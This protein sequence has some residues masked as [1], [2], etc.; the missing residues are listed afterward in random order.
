MEN[1][2]V[3]SVSIFDH[4]LTEKEASDCE[5]MNYSTAVENHVLD[6][7][8]I[9]ENKFI[10]LYASLGDKAICYL[11][12]ERKN[13]LLTNSVEFK[14]YLIKGLREKQFHL[15]HII[16]PT[17][18]ITIR[19]GYDRTDLFILD[20]RINICDVSILYE[21]VS[22]NGL[23]ILEDTVMDYKEYVKSCEE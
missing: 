18:D 15:H 21:A 3:L 20:E 12:N 7:Y 8:L 13:V 22:L 9:G 11:D 1:V 14:S 17:K 2:R 23:F 10:N 5:I 16:Y 6:K 4:W 19:G